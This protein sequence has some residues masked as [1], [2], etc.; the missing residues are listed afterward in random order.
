MDATSIFPLGAEPPAKKAYVDA[1]EETFQQVVVDR[2]FEV[3]VVVDFWA[4]WCG[5]CR[6][7]GPVLEKLA[8]EN[9]GRWD[10]VKIDVDANPRLAQAFQVQGI[11]AVKAVVGGRLA[12]EFTG[13]M[14]EA[15]IK[16][17]LD[18]VE[19]VRAQLLGPAPAVAAGADD[20]LAPDDLEEG[21]PAS[22]EELAERDAAAARFPALLDA[23]RMG[24]DTRDPARAELLE[25]FEL[26][27]ED[28]PRVLRARRD[29]A[30]ALF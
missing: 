10:L 8:T 14:P 1:T 19:V 21:I 28:D 29:L 16:L 5:P 13:A 30:S 23:V 22:P 7:L 11:P 27:P 3:P 4:E 15:Q 20:A 6:Q 2:S 26:F 12:H 18:E 25:L 9:A 17:W 24:G